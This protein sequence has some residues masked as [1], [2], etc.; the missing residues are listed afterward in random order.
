[1]KLQSSMTL[2]AMV[3]DSDLVFQQVLD[4]FFDGI[5]DDKTVKIINSK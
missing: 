2:F 1:M 5:A 4:K 3:E